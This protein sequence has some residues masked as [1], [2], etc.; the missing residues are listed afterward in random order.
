[1]NKVNAE[2]K[3]MLLD[4]Y[5]DDVELAVLISRT[6]ELINSANSLKTLANNQNEVMLLNS[7]AKMLHN[8]KKKMIKMQKGIEKIEETRRTL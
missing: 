5:I 1:M 2:Y 4:G 6:N 3:F 7:I 8:E